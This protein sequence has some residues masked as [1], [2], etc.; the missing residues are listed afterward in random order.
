ME[1]YLGENQD[2]YIKTV[3][4][5]LYDLQKKVLDV[6]LARID[7]YKQK[8]WSNDEITHKFNRYRLPNIYGMRKGEIFEFSHFFDHF[9]LLYFVQKIVRPVIALPKTNAKAH[10]PQILQKRGKVPQPRKTRLFRKSGQRDANSGIF[11]QKG[12]LSVRIQRVQAK[13]QND[14]QAV[15]HAVGGCIFISFDF[16]V[17]RTKLVEKC[18]NEHPEWFFGYT[19]AVILVK[20]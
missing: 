4:I 18:K 20:N 7:V 5:C 19:K 16:Q 9:R 8:W 13:G 12:R 1:D 17:R 3:G 10:S 15:R 11:P 6:K 2:R 14:V